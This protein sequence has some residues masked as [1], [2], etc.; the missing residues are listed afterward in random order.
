[1]ELSTF[2]NSVSITPTDTMF[3]RDNIT[4]TYHLL[5]E[6]GYPLGQND[7]LPPGIIYT[8]FVLTCFLTLFGVCGNALVLFVMHRTTNSS[9]V[10]IF[11]IN[12]LAAFDT[13]AVVTTAL[14]QRSLPYVFGRDVRALNN[15]TCKLFISLF[16][17]S[18]FSSATVVIHI[19]IERFLIVWYPQRAKLL[20]SRKTVVKSVSISVTFIALLC[21]V[22]SFINSEVKHG[23]CFVNVNENENEGH[24]RALI[25][26]VLYAVLASTP[27]LL[28]TIF[29][30][31]TI[32]KLCK[33]RASSPSK[34]IRTTIMLLSVVIAHIFLGGIPAITLL[35]LSSIGI[36][37]TDI[38][39]SWIP[40]VVLLN[41]TINI[42]L[43]SGFD[44]QFRER[45]RRVFR[46]CCRDRD[47]DV[48][49]SVIQDDGDIDV[50]SEN[51]VLETAL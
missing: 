46:C 45:L 4:P 1:M 25:S 37:L 39:T 3:L 21:S 40:L 47:P 28:L 12:V 17:F 9:T 27:S 2:H 50:C 29:T 44:E 16:Q 33:K 13:I 14:N 24:D 8:L 6:T 41:Y 7:I 36:N 20:F 48:M 23:F 38:T 15:L 31:L 19:S 32:F 5:N 43:Y 49:S 22:M 10:H 30:M 51:R 26:I 34:N 11:L 42:L 18:S 35:S